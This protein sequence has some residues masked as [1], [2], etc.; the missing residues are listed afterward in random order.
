MKNFVSNF[1]TAMLA[2]CAVIITIL[3]V[4]KELF[5]P[6]PNANEQIIENWQK[7]EFLGNQYDPK[8]GKVQIIKFYDYECPYCK[9]AEPPMS[10]VYKKYSD[11]VNIKYAHFPLQE[12]HPYA[13]KLPWPWNVHENRK[14]LKLITLSYLL[15]RI[16][17]ELFHLLSWLRR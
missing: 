3:V 13:K 12:I 4:R 9:Q 8:Q 14:G 1:L 17:L 5:P 2:L 10:D 6:A 16:K 11:V 7:I 15:N